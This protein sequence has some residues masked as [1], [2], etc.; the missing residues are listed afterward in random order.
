M[1]KNINLPEIRAEMLL[2][3]LYPEA[4]NQW[5]VQNEGS[6][7]RNYN[8][9][10]FAIDE[11][12]MVAETARDSF[13]K[14]LPQ[15]LITQETDLKGEDVAEKF[16]Q[17]E[18]RLRFLRETFKPFDTFRFRESVFVESQID[19]LLQGKLSYILNTYF[20][21]DLEKI[22]NEHVREAAI[23]L[24]YVSR[25]R[26]DFGFVGNLLQTLFKCEVNMTIGRYSHTDTTRSWLPMVR[27]ELIIP[28]LTP[29]EYREKDKDLEPLR[30]FLC[31]WLIPY[32]VWCQIDIKEYEVPQQ[33]N[34]RLTLGYNTEV[35]VE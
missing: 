11:E 15:G 33:T 32:E 16:K 2:N 22:E 19:D 25:R 35:R 6:F 29:E 13:V 5:I 26:G 31:E 27:Y 7:F 24:P 14:L 10:L 17:L 12:K 28:G 4:A 21:I 3:Y 1:I 34:T 18:L 8:S 23:L 9:D 30:E 20:G